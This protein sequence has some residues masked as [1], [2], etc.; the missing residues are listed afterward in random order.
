MA[1]NAIQFQ[2]EL[3]LAALLKEYG[4]EEQYEAAFIKA[5]AARVCLPLLRPY[6]R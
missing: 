6:N 5:L 3:S 1:I 2:K 4:T